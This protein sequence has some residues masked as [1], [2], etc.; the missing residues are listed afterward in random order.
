MTTDDVPDRPYRRMVAP[1]RNHDRSIVFSAPPAERPV[2][3]PSPVRGHLAVAGIGVSDGERI[4]LRDLSFE[5]TPG[6]TNYLVG[7]TAE[8]QQA[9]LM[10]LLGLETPSEGTIHLDGIGLEDMALAERRALL[11]L[12]VTDPWIIAGTLA[13]NIAFGLPA[14][15]REQVDHAAELAGIEAFA[16]R[17]DHGLDTPLSEEGPELAPAERRLVGLARAIVR[18]P[19]LLLIDQPTKH[20]DE[21]ARSMV[22]QAVEQVSEGRT[23]LI[24]TPRSRL[25]KRVDR[26]LRIRGGR[27][28]DAAQ[29]HP[30][31]A[32]DTDWVRSR[33]FRR[34][35]A[36]RSVSAINTGDE[37]I[38][39]HQAISL[40]ERSAHTE[41]WVAWERDAG[42]S[43]QVKLPRRSPATYVALEEL[44]REYR[45]G[46]LLTHAGLSKPLYA[47]F[48]LA[49]PY[50][51]YEH[52]Q[53][54][55]LADLIVANDGGPD[56]ATILRVGYELARTLSYLHQQGFAH[57][58]LRPEVV[59]V[60]PQGTVVTDLKM[61]L[62]LGDEQVRFY[63][64][65]QY[66]VL[67]A[68]QLRGSPAAASMDIFALGALLYQAA[69]GVLATDT[70]SN[71]GSRRASIATRPPRRRPHGIPAP[72][73]NTDDNRLAGAIASIVE[74]LTAS[75]PKQ[76]PTAE[77]VNALIRPHL[78]PTPS[79]GPS[80]PST[81][82]WISSARDQLAS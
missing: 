64:R 35:G 71:F 59:V 13:E 45:T 23:T 10:L 29:T 62:R 57:L 63:R 60:S 24:A 77:E 5:L 58:D 78:L 32:S 76:R 16:G 51:V 21:E 22:I 70:N 49:N 1:G 3:P 33:D 65:E 30:T 50:S 17:L 34:L 19:A 25:V 53:G 36:A 11:G 18:E 75:D 37:F 41:T 61:A 6:S 54:P 31:S 69:N 15:G 47:Q 74:Q 38:P 80:S 48:A 55:T 28:V 39:G 43:V 44:T 9:M 20:L 27:L 66:G 8:E 81:S 42:R 52:L 68:E 12:A 79:T 73:A 56:P 82:G 40:V 72:T 4:V 67:A 2:R 7:S 46:E 26:I 14:V